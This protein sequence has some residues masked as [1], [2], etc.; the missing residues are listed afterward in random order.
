[1]ALYRVI[2]C[3]LRHKQASIQ[4]LSAAIAIYLHS[5]SYMI[6][7]FKLQ[8]YV[9][10]IKTK[11]SLALRYWMDENNVR[12]TNPVVVCLNLVS[13]SLSSSGLDSSEKIQ[14]GSVSSA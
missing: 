6:L 4:L 5:R 10:G 12:L 9:N 8:V 3:L 14:V 13:T 2:Q 1:M 7:E 11:W